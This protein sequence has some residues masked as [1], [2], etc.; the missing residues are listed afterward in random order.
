MIKVDVVK[1]DLDWARSCLVG[2][3]NVSLSWQEFQEELY[4]GGHYNIEVKPLGGARVLL[5]ESL[6]NS[7]YNL[8]NE[9]SKWLNSL[10]VH[11]N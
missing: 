7:L 1:E 3:L 9:D 2:T 11:L 5:S 8:Q 10:F 4:S 6:P